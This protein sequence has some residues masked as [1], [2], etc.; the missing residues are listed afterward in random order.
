MLSINRSL[1]LQIKNG[2]STQK[3]VQIETQKIAVVVLLFQHKVPVMPMRMHGVLVA[4]P[5]MQHLLGRA[6]KQQQTCQQDGQC[7]PEKPV[8]HQP[9]S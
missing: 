4:R 2:N 3:R 9:R 8:F 5:G 1:F 6:A 7:V